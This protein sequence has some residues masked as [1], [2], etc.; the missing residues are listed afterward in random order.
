MMPKICKD[1]LA[2]GIETHRAA[3][4]PGPRCYTHHRIKKGQRSEQEHERRILANFQITEELY[5]EIY[6]S[7]G[8]KCFVCQR[9]TG[10]T[11]RLAVEH[12]HSLCEDHDPEKGCPKCIRCLACGPCNLLLARYDVKALHRAITVLTDAP[13][14][15]VIK[16]WMS[17]R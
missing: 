9:A 1:C 14:Q 16:E 15:K 4:Y 2:E 6:R 8:G 17:G 5:Q 12:N 7:Q 13:A 3:L 11:K 10:A